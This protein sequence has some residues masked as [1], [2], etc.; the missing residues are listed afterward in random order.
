MSVADS[1]DDSEA[2]G[3]EPFA[4]MPVVKSAARTMH[5]LEFLAE[6]FGQPTR[7]RDVAEALGA[8]RSSTY[9]LL[10]TLVGNGW[11]RT[12]STRTFYTLGIRALLVGTAFID[13]DPYVRVVRPVLLEVSQQLNETLHLARLDGPHVVYLATQESRKE[14]RGISRVGRR[15]PSHATSL[16]KAVLAH[17]P[18]AVPAQ[19]P[20]VTDTTITDPEVLREQLAESRR[21]G[22]AIDEGETSPGLRCF[23]FALRYANPVTDAI[24][25]SVPVERLDQAREAEI[26]EAMS[27][28]RRR[29]EEAAPLQ[30]TF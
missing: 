9:A 15:L 27:E 7:L 26:V 8:P 21:R 30:G 5:L 12:D 3:G 17:R 18:D 29:I 19:L 10:S 4:G 24:S 6:R 22:Y 11:V 25:C 13:A 20:A 28:A 23:G 2:R 16:G 1:A 14:I